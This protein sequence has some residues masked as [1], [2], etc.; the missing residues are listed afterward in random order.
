M[1]QV[2][3]IAAAA[4]AIAGAGI[5]SAARAECDPANPTACAAPAAHATKGPLT[6]HPTKLGSARRSVSRSGR[7]HTARISPAHKTAAKTAAAKTAAAKTAT[8][9]ATKAAT[10]TAPSAA[11]AA[12]TPDTSPL[13][14][15]VVATVPF[16]AAP[17]AMSS[18]TSGFAT[19]QEPWSTV[20]AFASPDAPTASARTW[21]ATLPGGVASAPVNSQSVKIV[22]SDQV[23]DLDRAADKADASKARLA[24]MSPVTSANAAESSAPTQAPH[25]G[26]ESWGG[27][28]YR[29]YASTLDAATS[30]VKAVLM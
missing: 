20:S 2:Y 28:L 23:N 3:L 12:A 14:P 4:F 10:K 11:V 1:K 29:I 26:K 24:Q 7:H 19:S 13:Q 5:T 16:A 6:L 17:V 21:A 15:K 25:D 27:W 8:K 9:T 22:P 30:A 18:S